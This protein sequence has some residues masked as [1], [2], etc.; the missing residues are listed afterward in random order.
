M[1][2][3]RDTTTHHP[4]T[5]TQQPHAAKRAE[6]HKGKAS[7]KINARARTVEVAFPDV[8]GEVACVIV[9]AYGCVCVDV[10]AE[11]AGV[12]SGRSIR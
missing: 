12:R 2:Y 5:I 1:R 10:W 9:F 6:T 11:P 4:R 3:T 7:D 8:H